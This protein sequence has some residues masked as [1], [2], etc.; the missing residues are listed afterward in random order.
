[1]AVQN[2]KIAVESLGLE[3]LGVEYFDPDLAD[4]LPVVTKVLAQNPD[5]LNLGCVGQNRAATPEACPPAR[6]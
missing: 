6:L 3:W 1:M 4:P 5:M 2:D